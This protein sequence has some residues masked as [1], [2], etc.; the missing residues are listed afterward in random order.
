M[1]QNR[2]AV[3]P[4]FGPDQYKAWEAVLA[5][6]CDARVQVRLREGTI[7]LAAIADAQGRYIKLY[8][9]AI[10]PLRPEM[11]FGLDHGAVD[12]TADGRRYDVRTVGRHN[13][14]PAAASRIEIG[15]RTVT[16]RSSSFPLIF[17]ITPPSWIPV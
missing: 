17:A 16:V 9:E 1:S 10:E 12:V 4:R 3:Q 8:H 5:G 7:T 11:G 15:T 6:R 14:L 13:E 2:A